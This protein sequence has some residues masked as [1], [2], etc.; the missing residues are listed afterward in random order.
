M[1]GDFNARCGH[2]QDQLANGK[3]DFTG[4]ALTIP[5]LSD[6]PYRNSE[7]ETTEGRGKELIES[8]I[9][10]GLAIING[11]KLG[12]RKGQ[13]T[14]FQYNGSSL[15]DYVICNNNTFE[16]INCILK[17]SCPNASFIKPSPHFIRPKNQGK[18]KIS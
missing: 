6:I 16:C 9:S 12:D 17:T 10:N 2:L 4:Q 8:C 3:N 11:R 5:E 1:Q 13:R 14:C 15:I 18:R 7:D